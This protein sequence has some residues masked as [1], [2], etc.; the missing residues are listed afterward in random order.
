MQ[1]NPLIS[2]ARTKHLQ[3]ICTH[4]LILGVLAA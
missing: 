2:F 1:L 4:I 3:S